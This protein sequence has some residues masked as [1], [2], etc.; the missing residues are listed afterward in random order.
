MYHNLLNIDQANKKSVIK[1]LIPV[2][3][4]YKG[5]IQLKEI[6]LNF[7]NVIKMNIMRIMCL[8]IKRQYGFKNC[9]CVKSLFLEEML[10]RVLVLLGVAVP[11]EIR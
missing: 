11:V 10:I 6:L 3:F 4:K 9:L 7:Y 2:S 5:N 1:N 8:I